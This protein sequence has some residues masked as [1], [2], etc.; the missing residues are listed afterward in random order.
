M[1]PHN[2]DWL[3]SMDA[4]RVEQCGSGSQTPDP[5]ILPQ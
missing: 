4:S 2:Y 5:I 3:L 1:F